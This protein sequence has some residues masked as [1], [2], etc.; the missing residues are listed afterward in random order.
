M[1]PSINVFANLLKSPRQDRLLVG[2]ELVRRSSRDE[3]IIILIAALHS[4]HAPVIVHQL[5][6]RNR[7]A[8][9]CSFDLRLR[10]LLLGNL[11]NLLELKHDVHVVPMQLSSPFC[12]LKEDDSILELFYLLIT[13][14]SKP[15]LIVLNTPLECPLIFLYGKLSIFK[16]SVCF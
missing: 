14:D 1:L 10:L 4:V 8:K 5:P 13:R 2:S 12:L 11:S 15:L 7:K 3:L 9:R 6:F 16:V